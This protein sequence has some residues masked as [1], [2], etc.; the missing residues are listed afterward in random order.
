MVPNPL[1]TPSTLSVGTDPQTLSVGTDSSKTQFSLDSLAHIPMVAHPFPGQ[2]LPLGHEVLGGREGAQLGG[3]TEDNS[4]QPTNGPTP[5]PHQ[6]MLLT[7][8]C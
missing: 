2:Y 6:T 8:L 4:G 5:Q 7:N 1:A 3:G